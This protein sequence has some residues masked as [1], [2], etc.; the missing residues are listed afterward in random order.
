M[1]VSSSI[2]AGQVVF[3]AFL[4]ILIPSC[5]WS[6]SAEKD[7]ATG[8][9]LIGDGLTSEK[10][11]LSDGA[12]IIQK[13]SFLYGETFYINFD[14][15]EGFE[16][17]GRGAFPSMQLVI[18]SEKGDTVLFVNDTYE[19]YSHG[20]ENSPLDLYGEV[21]LADP[22]HSGE[23]YA[24]YVKITDKF[25]NGK[26]R[27]VLEFTVE[28]D[29]GIL[30][31]KNQVSYREVYLYS[32]QRGKAITNGKAEFNENIYMLFEGLEGFS[33]EEGKVFLGLSLEVKDANGNL[34]LDEADLLDDEGMNHE[35][36]NE[37]LAP[38]FILSGSTIANPVNCKVRIWDKRGTA[39]I[40]ASAEIMVE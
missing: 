2:P 10:V 34:I 35:M 36:V 8:L 33:R 26:Y 19:G 39:W 32:Q 14:G 15:M 20:I 4:F 21:T 30:L 37:Q 24:L 25:G 16:R 6:K 7:L 23:A 40:N 3:F 28:P 12:D 9:K 1:K 27:A 22:I 13:N 29:A 11:Y 18:V 17:Q 31:T 5:Q 38:H